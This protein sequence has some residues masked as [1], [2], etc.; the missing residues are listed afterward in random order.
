M[1]A[2]FFII[3]AVE[4]AEQLLQLSQAVDVIFGLYSFRSVGKTPLLFGVEWF[5]YL[6]EHLAV[7][8]TAFTHKYRIV[9]CAIFECYFP[10]LYIAYIFRF[11]P[12]K[13]FCVLCP[14]FRT[15]N[16]KMLFRYGLQKGEYACSLF[17]FAR[18]RAFLNAWLVD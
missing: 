3:T 9:L 7:V 4:L 14:Y 15:E 10:V 11:V 2:L 18:C 1:V 16:F 8:C 13:S 12:I 17:L 6:V 5:V